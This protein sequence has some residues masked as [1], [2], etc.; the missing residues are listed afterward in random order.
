MIGGGGHVG[1]PL[2][3]TFAD[4]GLRTVIF[5]VNAPAVDTIRAGPDALH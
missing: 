4:H 3:L 5:D 1:L 2:A